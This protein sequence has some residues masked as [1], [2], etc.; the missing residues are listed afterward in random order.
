MKT[1]E[2]EFD[3]VKTFREIK[4][5]ISM[6]LIGKSAQQIKDYLR[7]NSLKLQAN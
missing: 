2:K 6:D 7:A 3:T 5:K 1:K 4:E